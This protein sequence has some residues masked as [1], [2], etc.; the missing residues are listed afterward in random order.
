MA[1]SVGPALAAPVSP[2]AGAV[3][4]QDTLQSSPAQPSAVPHNIVAQ[5][6]ISPLPADCCTVQPSVDSQQQEMASGHISSPLS[7]GCLPHG[8]RSSCDLYC[9]LGGGSRACFS[10]FC[11]LLLHPV[12]TTY[13]KQEVL[14]DKQRMGGVNAFLF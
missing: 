6:D 4:V 14:K 8:I 2:T 10:K 3:Q 9:G 1:V 13:T 11:G 7:L 12:P 5:V